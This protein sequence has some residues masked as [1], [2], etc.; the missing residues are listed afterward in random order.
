[1]AGEGV[2]PAPHGYARARGKAR[3][4]I[5]REWH[6]SVRALLRVRSQPA[7]AAAV[8]APWRVFRPAYALNRINNVHVVI[9]ITNACIHVAAPCPGLAGQ[10]GRAQWTAGPFPRCGPVL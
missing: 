1:M 2:T 10:Q 4:I 9:A 8:R 6:L 7:A 5:N 3:R